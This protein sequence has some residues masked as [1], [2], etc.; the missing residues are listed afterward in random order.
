MTKVE[1]LEEEIK[2]LSP[3]ELAELEWLDRDAEEWDRQIERDAA[4]EARYSSEK[5]VADHRARQKPAEFEAPHQPRFWALPLTP[6]RNPGTGT[7]HYDLLKANPLGIRR[8][9]PAPAVTGPFGLAATTEL[10]AKQLE[11]GILWGWIGSHA[12]YE[13]I[14]AAL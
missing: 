1:S 10:S 5:S 12:E 4:S 9:S 11:D 3:E 8:H 6:G 7:S 14:L 13:K 2:R